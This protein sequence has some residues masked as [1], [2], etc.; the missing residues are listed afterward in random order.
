M[1][2]IFGGLPGTG[3]TTIAKILAQKLKAIYLRIDTIE[4][5]LVE[6]GIKKQ[7]I[8]ALGYEVG[9][10]I[11]A[12]NLQLNLTV[13]A[14]SV[15]PVNISREAWRNLGLNAGVPFLEIEI[16][17]SDKEEHRKRIESRVT[18]IVN[19]KLPNWQSVLEREYD[20]W[21]HDHLVIDTAKVSA[22]EAVDII[23]NA[24][25]M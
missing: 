9:Y 18:D 22:N 25:G 7:H 17:C 14:D 21:S 6:A 16:I 3:K 1:L 11:A 8:N 20:S 4:Q 15:N 12:E 19:L 23:M 5:A 13:I 24:I 10:A 2:I